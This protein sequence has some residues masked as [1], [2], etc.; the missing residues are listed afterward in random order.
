MVDSQHH[1][2][3][4]IFDITVILGYI[5]RKEL[6]YNLKQVGRPMHQVQH[7]LSHFKLQEIALGH[8]M[9]RGSWT[10]GTLKFMFKL[11]SMFA[12]DT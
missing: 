9:F 7:F 10:Q 11:I 8:P 3:I 1:F 5:S 12:T 6:Y 2:W 4:N